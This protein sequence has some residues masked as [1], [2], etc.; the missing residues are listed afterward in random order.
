MVILGID[1]SL[2]H[3][4]YV[5]LDGDSGRLLDYAF[6][7][8]VKK[9]VRFDE[10]H[11]FHLDVKKRDGEDRDCFTARRMARNIEIFEY[12]LWDHFELSTQI[13][14]VYCCIEGYAYNIQNTKAIYQIAEWT[15]YVKNCLYGRAKL[16]TYDPALMKRFSVGNGKATKKDMVEGFFKDNPKIELVLKQD[17]HGEYDGPGTDVADAYFLAKMLWIELKLRNCEVCLEDLPEYQQG[18]LTDN[19][20]LAKAFIELS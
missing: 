6:L 15:G 1:L 3:A 16:R 5:M 20:I 13:Q 4:G 11:G 10:R 2:N 19:G 14:E 18:A 7:S 9:D 12:I 17:K 8:D